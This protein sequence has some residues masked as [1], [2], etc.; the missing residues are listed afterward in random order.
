MTIGILF[1][2]SYRFPTFLVFA[3]SLCLLTTLIPA[4][5]QPIILSGGLVAEPWPLVL[6]LVAVGLPVVMVSPGPALERALPTPAPTLRAGVV[7]TSALVF[8]GLALL[9]TRL[10][11]RPF[12][13]AARN[14][15]L[16]AAMAFLTGLWWGARW[17]WAAPSA[18]CLV[19]WLYGVDDANRAKFWAVLMKGDGG[20][21]FVSSLVLALVCSGLWVWR[22]S[23]LGEEA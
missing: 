8:V 11:D 5:P 6:G 19:N 16:C 7:V 10:I 23:R 14:F 2:R 12:D 1:L 3:G 9:T 4:D 18:F 20:G 15:A 17:A 21:L 13:L 22:G